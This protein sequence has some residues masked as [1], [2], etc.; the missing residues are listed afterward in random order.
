MG[1]EAFGYEVDWAREEALVA[2]DEVDDG[3][4]VEAR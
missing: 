1:D 2:P 4:D 3:P